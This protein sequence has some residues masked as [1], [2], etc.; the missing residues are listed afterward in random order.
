M[1]S[2]IAVWEPRGGAC[3]ESVFTATIVFPSTLDFDAQIKSDVNIV[4]SVPVLRFLIKHSGAACVGKR[5]QSCFLGTCDVTVITF[6]F[7]TTLQ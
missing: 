7:G 4:G 1:L 6:S 5:D 2:L 3:H